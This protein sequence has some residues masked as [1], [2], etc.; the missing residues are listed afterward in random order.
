M[1]I[2]LKKAVAL[3]NIPFTIL[4][5]GSLSLVKNFF[6]LEGIP[7]M[8]KRETKNPKTVGIAFAK[9]SSIPLAIAP[10]SPLIIDLSVVRI[11]SIK[12]LTSSFFSIKNL[13]TSKIALAAFNTPAPGTRMLISHII[14]F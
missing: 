4:V 11:E 1:P 3:L 6:I 2:P 13:I 7:P 9:A 8:P 5:I 10:I 12:A 14:P